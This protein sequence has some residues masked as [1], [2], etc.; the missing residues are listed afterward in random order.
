VNYRPFEGQHD[1]LRRAPAVAMGWNKA[2]VILA[3]K[4]TGNSRCLNRS[5]AGRARQ[6]VVDGRFWQVAVA[7]KS[8]PYGIAWDDQELW[9]LDRKNKCI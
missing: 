9:A 1:S 8:I 7:L 4:S 2:W 3:S 6:P 5:H